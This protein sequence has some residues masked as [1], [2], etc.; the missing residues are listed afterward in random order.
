MTVPPL[1]R[2]L[3]AF[4]VRVAARLRH[5]GLA[6]TAASLAFTTLLGIVPL[7]TVA[8]ATVTRFPMFQRWLDALE[9]FLL[10]HMLPQSASA[11]VHTHIR[12][13]VDKAAGLTGLSIAL[14]FVT[15]LLLIATVERE[16]NLIWGIRRRR[17]WVARIVVYALG[18]SVG[19]LLIGGSVWATTRLLSASIA[20]MPL[21]EA[22]TDAVLAPAPLALSTLA[23]ALLYRLVPATRVPWR[24]AFAGALVAA[25]AF[26]AAKQAFALYLTQVPTLRDIYGTLAAVPAFLVWIYLC[27]LIVLVGAAITATLALPGEATLASA[28]NPTGDATPPSNAAPPG[29][30][31]DEALMRRFVARAAQ[32]ACCPGPRCLPN[33]G[34]QATL[35]R[36]F[37]AGVHSP[38]GPSSRRPAGPSGR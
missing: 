29:D 4:G 17:P 30:P 32:G 8:V 35:R 12:E 11:L 3:A 33:R 2:R 14:I 10:E 24:H 26:E 34:R 7:A 23:L 27:W 1:P 15:A 28:A 31:G 19:P 6:R 13:F 5:V 37:F 22:L 21:D 38:C 18:A 36:V 9:A 16:I 20:K 25:V